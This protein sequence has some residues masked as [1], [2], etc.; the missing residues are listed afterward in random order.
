[1]WAELFRELGEP[2]LGFIFCAGDE[3]AVLARVALLEQRALRK[4]QIA[5]F[6]RDL[7][8]AAETGGQAAWSFDAKLEGL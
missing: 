5:G 1:M 7:Q 6:G 3:P 2:E 4:R 8:W